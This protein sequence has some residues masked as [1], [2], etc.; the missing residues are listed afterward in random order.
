MAIIS[1]GWKSERIWGADSWHS[2]CTYVAGRGK[3]ISFCIA[4]G[5]HCVELCRLMVCNALTVGDIGREHAALDVGT[6]GVV[7]PTR[8]TAGRGG[9][10]VARYP[11]Q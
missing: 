6:R 10:A 3:R 9:V 8:N 11:M 4:G 5:R 7:I 2:L 1:C